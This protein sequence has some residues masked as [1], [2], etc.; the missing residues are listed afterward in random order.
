VALKGWVA[1]AVRGR[2]SFAVTVGAAA[3]S[4]A[5]AAGSPGGEAVPDTAADQAAIRDVMARGAEAFNRGDAPA[6]AAVYASDA[7]L[8]NVRG[9]HLR[10]QAEIERGLARALATRYKGARMTRGEVDIRFLRPDVALA[11]VTNEIAVAGE[12]GATTVHREIGLRVFVK[13]GGTW[14]IAA[15]HNTPLP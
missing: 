8:V 12:G 5:L 10:G 3:C 15:L 13:E 14:R 9:D 4:F 2:L 7:D 11:Y 6:A 1:A